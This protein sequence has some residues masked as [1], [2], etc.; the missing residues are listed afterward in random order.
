LNNEHLPI[1]K[2]DLWLKSGSNRRASA[3]IFTITNVLEVAPHRAGKIFNLLFAPVPQEDIQR[4]INR[5]T[6]ATDGTPT[7]LKTQLTIQK[8]EEGQEFN[9][10]VH[11]STS[12]E[13][14]IVQIIVDV[15]NRDMSQSLNPAQCD[16]IFGFADS[17]MPEW[18]FT[19][20]GEIGA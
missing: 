5:F 16:R 13:Q 9:L 14:P 7:S 4:L 2:G 20:L 8:D 12:I 6:P 18:A 19:F 11:V 3:A 15:N 10:S 17:I 1:F